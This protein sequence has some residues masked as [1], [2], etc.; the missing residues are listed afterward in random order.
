MFQ[1]CPQ[2][3]W[4]WMFYSFGAMGF[5]WVFFWIFMYREVRGSFEEEFIQPPK[6]ITVLLATTYHKREVFAVIMHAMNYVSL[7][8]KY[9]LFT[10]I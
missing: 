4:Q 9:I 7:Q 8:P 3:S 5:L 2:L 1:I 6:V 10:Y